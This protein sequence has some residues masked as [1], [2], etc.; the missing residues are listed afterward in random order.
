MEKR[1]PYTV[2]TQNIMMQPISSGCTL[3]KM[4]YAALSLNQRTVFFY[5]PGWKNNK[6]PTEHFEF[7]NLTSKIYLEAAAAFSTNHFASL[8]L[9]FNRYRILHHASIL[10]FFFFPE[11]TKL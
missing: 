11:E 7:V 5:N 9:F 4:K 8:T 6:L 1:A 2:L 10:Y 3:H